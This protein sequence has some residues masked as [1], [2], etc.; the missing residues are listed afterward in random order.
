MNNR[1]IYG[2]VWPGLKSY[3]EADSALFFGRDADIERLA[4]AIEY[5]D[6]CTVYGKS[7][8]G[9]SSLLMAGVFPKLRKKGFLPVWI[10]LNHEGKAS[11]TQQ[12][13][14]AVEQSAKIFFV[15]IEENC[16]AF[17]KGRDETLWE[18]FHRHSFKNAFGRSLECVIVLDQFEEVFTAKGSDKENFFA[19]LADL[20]ENTIPAAVENNETELPYGLEAEK[21]GYRIVCSIRE[22]FFPRFEE[23]TAPYG[24]FRKNRICI[25]PF[26]REQAKEAITKPGKEIV[27]DAVAETILDVLQGNSPSIEP[28]LLSVFCSRLDIK[29]QQAGAQRIDKG[30][31]EADKNDILS[32]FYRDAMSGVAKRTVELLENHLLSQSGFRA[33][34]AIEEA[35]KAGI[36]REELRKLVGERLLQ[37]FRR[38]G[39]EFIEYSH[40]IVV[41]TVREMRKSASRERFRRQRRRTRIYFAAIFAFIFAV[42][43]GAFCSWRYFYKEHVAYYRMFVKKWGHP[44]GVGEP[45]SM[46]F[47]RHRYC[48]FR[49]TSSGKYSLDKNGSCW[50]IFKWRAVPAYAHKVEAV[51]GLLRPQCDNNMST[52]LWSEDDTSPH[53]KVSE[54]SGSQGNLM[55]VEKAGVPQEDKVTHSTSSKPDNTVTKQSKHNS[56]ESKHNN[57]GRFPIRNSGYLTEKE[58]KSVCSWE[59]FCDGEGNVIKENAF[60]AQ[61]NVVWSCLYVPAYK[62][63][64]QSKQAIAHFVS[65][66]GYQVKMRGDDAEYVRTVYDEKNGY[67]SMIVYL[68]KNGN[69]T[70]G[71]D[72]ANAREQKYDTLGRIRFQASMGWDGK[73]FY[74]MIDS[75]GNCAQSTSW[76]GWKCETIESLNTNGEAI[77]TVSGVAKAVK[78]YDHW[79]NLVRGTVYGTNGQTIK[80]GSAVPFVEIEYDSYGRRTK[81]ITEANEGEGGIYG[82]ADINKAQFSFDEYGNETNVLFVALSGRHEGVRQICR[83]FDGKDKCI[84]EWTLD[85]NGSLATNANGIAKM[86][87]TFD[88]DRLIQSDL[89]SLPEQGGMWGHTNIHH[90]VKMFLNGDDD[91][92]TNEC[93]FAIN[94]EPASDNDGIARI[95]NKFSR[96]GDLIERHYYAVKGEGG[97]WGQTNVMHT[98]QSYSNGNLV[99][100]RNLDW[101]GNLAGNNYGIARFEYFYDSNGRQIRVD[102]FGVNEARGIYGVSNCYQLICLLNDKGKTVVQECFDAEGRYSCENNGMSVGNV[103]YYEDGETVKTIDGLSLPGIG[104]GFDG[105]TLRIFKTFRKNG[106]LQEDVA[107][108][109]NGSKHIRKY[110]KRGAPISERFIDT[111][112]NDLYD[113][114]VLGVPRI[115]Y[116]YGS[117]LLGVKVNRDKCTLVKYIDNKGN[118]VANRFGIAGIRTEYNFDGN[119]TAKWFV[120]EHGDKIATED[121]AICSEVFG[122]TQAF[123]AGVREG[124]II[125][126]FGS[127]NIAN[128]DQID[129]IGENIK[130]LAGKKKIL[131]VA[132]LS[133]GGK[134]EIKTFSFSEEMMGIRISDTAMAKMR[135]DEVKMAMR[136]I[137]Y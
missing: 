104:H 48:S 61:S 6:V 117:K 78:E 12:I 8:A 91:K 110:N 50:N 57:D 35:E 92:I 2:S 118:G 90:S 29:R 13:I 65:E 43:G 89:Y 51:D 11:T 105:K 37:A 49:L 52:Y 47:V 80:C 60:N 18:W 82:S 67:E 83:T 16:A 129:K 59:F 45:L 7:G 9:K 76:D 127:Y 98:A 130:E 22:D 44:V 75:A 136:F 71:I 96:H 81:I 23:A 94:G 99:M 115:N 128:G 28:A 109:F 25:G 112:G 21:R 5:E 107:T 56:D 119:Q 55:G 53:A 46:E 64:P 4:N 87:Y 84:R 58:L 106:K 1:H 62:D 3:T 68:D 86:E 125:C 40:D 36:K 70:G 111:N 134:C 74:R 66:D 33:P 17:A 121:I 113:M 137:S 26:G 135:L 39:D 124:D 120:D 31:V 126:R 114:G 19:D 63:I 27:D 100:E 103:E 72:R 41:R 15:E 30:S 133:H 122:R 131:I 54:Q 116:S 108:F 34:W 38:D 102:K 95:I 79:G 20:G 85:E 77:A 10:R 101:D 69:I 42:A 14:D 32:G 97:V 88:G 93:Y 73:S 132:R 123:R 24:I